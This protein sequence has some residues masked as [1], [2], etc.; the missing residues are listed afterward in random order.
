MPPPPYFDPK[1][2]PGMFLFVDI[3]II[4]LGLGDSKAEFLLT[5]MEVLTSVSA[6]MLTQSCIP[7]TYVP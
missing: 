1:K 4:L 7:N 5:Q 6:P 3:E 2:L